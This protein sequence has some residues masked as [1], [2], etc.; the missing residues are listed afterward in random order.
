MTLP[1]TYLKYFGYVIDDFTIDQS[2]LL[3]LCYRWIYHLTHLK[4]FGYVID[5]FTID[6]LKLSWRFI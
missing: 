4:Y 2:K 6:P 3:W 5:D 1:L